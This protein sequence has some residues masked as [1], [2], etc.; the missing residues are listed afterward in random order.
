MYKVKFKILQQGDAG[1]AGGSGE[2][3][4]PAGTTTT[5]TQPGAT[6]TQQ[7]ANIPAVDVNAEIAKALAAQQAE[8]QSQLKAA[9][10]H[11][12][13]K[14][15]AD[16]QLL[17][18]GKLKEFAESKSQEAA[19]FKA[20]F[21]SSQISNALLTASQGAI[22]PA[23]V[24]ELLKGKAVCDEHGKVTIEGKPVTD[25]V[26]AFLAEKPFLAKSVGDTGSGTTKNTN[27]VQTISRAQLD[28][29]SAADRS[30]HI[31]SGGRIVD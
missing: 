29:L 16:A 9:T 31:S 4:Q 15:L 14:A 2:G 23:T 19:Q 22:D 13:V 25:A 1:G 6:A 17:E 21:E 7:A 11:S 18:Q 30:K 5:T 8:F 28:A 20:K 10:G 27:G 12:D 24:V 26:S 3:G